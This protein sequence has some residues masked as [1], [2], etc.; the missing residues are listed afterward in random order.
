[1]RSLSALQK[2]LELL[3]IRGKGRLANIIFQALKP[4]EVECHPLRDL[5]VF[6]RPG[7]RIERLMWG[8]VY[9]RELVALFKRTLKPGMTVLDVGANVGYFSAIAAALVGSGGSVHA[10]E[11]VPESFT[12]LQRNLSNFRWCHA[13]PFAVGDVT[14]LAKIHF[15]EQELGWAS[16]FNDNNLACATDA[17]AIS[18]DAWMIQQGLRGLNLLKIDVEGGEYRVLQGAGRMLR[19]FRPVVTAELNC[20]CLSRDHHTPEDVVQLLK[21]AEYRT[22]SFNNGVLAI[23]TEAGR[24]LSD[25]RAYTKNP[26]R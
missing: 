13:Y 10:F 1:M 18:L 11:P 5:T 14:G 26:F 19:D 15:N 4:E 23:P 22:F 7:Q 21:T 16:L 3:P 8:G 9:E 25:L 24:L 2:T 17:Q 20:V 12:R 6:L